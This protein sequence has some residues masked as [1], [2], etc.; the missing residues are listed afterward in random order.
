MTRLTSRRSRAGAARRVDEQSRSSDDIIAVQ[1]FLRGLVERTYPAIVSL[2]ATRYRLS[3]QGRRGSLELTTTLP[4]IAAYGGQR[5]AL[6]LSERDGKSRLMLAWQVE[7]NTPDAVIDSANRQE[8]EVL[9]AVDSLEFRYYG[10]MQGAKTESWYESWQDQPSLPRLVRILIKSSDTSMPWP[11][12]DI[13]PRLDVDA[14]CVL[15]RL[16]RQC[17][18]R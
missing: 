13:A 8:L 7:R 1:S 18:G 2:S 16:S 6:Y 5:A 4:Q 15:D 9:S 11:P 3:F 12:L 14:T 10:Q 17:R